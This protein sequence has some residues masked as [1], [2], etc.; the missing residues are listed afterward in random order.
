MCN[1]LLLDSKRYNRK[2]IFSAHFVLFVPQ[3]KSF[4]NGQVN[5][6]ENGCI[7]HIEQMNERNKMNKRCILQYVRRKKSGQKELTRTSACGK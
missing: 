6:C 2:N 5:G 7:L 1:S 3:M 4:K